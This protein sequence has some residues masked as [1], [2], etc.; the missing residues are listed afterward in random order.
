MPDANLSCY[1]HQLERRRIKKTVGA[2]PTDGAGQLYGT[3]Y[4]GRSHAIRGRGIPPADDQQNIKL[5][6]AKGYVAGRSHLQSD[7][8]LLTRPL[9]ADAALAP[10]PTRRIHN[11]SYQSHLYG[12]AAHLDSGSYA[13]QHRY[14]P[15]RGLGAQ[16]PDRTISLTTKRVINNGWSDEELLAATATSG[17]RSRLLWTRPETADEIMRYRN[18][19]GIAPVDYKISAEDRTPAPHTTKVSV[20]AS[21]DVYMTALQEYCRNKIR[22]AVVHQIRLG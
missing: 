10:R 6:Q 18:S 16:A 20:Q 8:D 9:T 7:Y 17:G 22:S 19:C 3:R 4:H 1:Y 14:K 21:R 5:T 15:S 13:E 2:P 12:A 11:T